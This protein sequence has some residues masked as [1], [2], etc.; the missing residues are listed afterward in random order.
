MRKHVGT[1]APQ[2]AVAADH[3]AAWS[4]RWALP[5][6]VANSCWYPARLWG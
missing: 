5:S 2:R 6:T 3:D 4:R 1:L